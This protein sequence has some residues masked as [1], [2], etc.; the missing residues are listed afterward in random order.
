M[1]VCT[2]PTDRAAGAQIRIL[3]QLTQMSQMLALCTSVLF[4]SFYQFG[5]EFGHKFRQGTVLVL[6][7]LLYL[8]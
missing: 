6:R 4:F 8:A 2:R 5:K 7:N 3:G 1:K